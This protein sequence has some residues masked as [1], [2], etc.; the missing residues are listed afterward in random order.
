MILTSLLAPLRVAV[1]SRRGVHLV[2][3]NLRIYRRQWLLVTSG[4]LEPVLYLAGI[5][6]GV[7]ALVGS[8][9]GISYS[10]FVA[11]ALLASSAMNGAIYEVCFN[12]FFKL[13]YAKLYE[14]VLS[15]PMTVGDIAAGEITFALMRGAVYAL[16]FVVVMSAMGLVSS[17]WTVLAFPAAVLIGFSFAAVGMACTTFLRSWQDFDLVQLFLLP[18]FLFSATFYPLSRYSAPLQAVVQWTPL[19]HGVHLVRGLTTG[20]VDAGL[21]VDVVYLV[22]LGVVGAAVAAWRLDRLLRK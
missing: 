6:I 13:R 16:V 5:G 14:A 18:L 12:L 22:A 10:H 11:P 20:A 21:L 15:T 9:D 4:L 3:R 2:E 1:P 8:I 19:Y 7:G 17:A